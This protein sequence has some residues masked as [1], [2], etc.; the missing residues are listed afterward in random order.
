MVGPDKLEVV[1]SFYYPSDMLSVDRGCEVAVSTYD[2]TA[3]KTFSEALSVLTSRHPLKGHVAMC[4]ALTRGAPSSK[5]VEL[6][7]AKPS[8]LAA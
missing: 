4:R 7:Q 1:A 5:A 2:Q 8:A 6:G 3:W